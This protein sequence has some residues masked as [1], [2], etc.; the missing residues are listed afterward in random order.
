M[1]K[2]K[3]MP[4]PRDGEM[5]E[6]FMD[7]CMSDPMMRDEM[8]DRDQRQEACEMRW[9]D[10]K[11]SGAR[12]KERIEGRKAYSVLNVKKITERHDVHVLNGV[13][14][15]PRVDRVKD[16]VDPMGARFSLPM[17]LLMQHNSDSPIGQVIFAE[18]N[19]K[20]IPFEAVIPKITEP[21][22]VKDRIDEAVHSLKYD[23]I[24]A[25]SIGF[26]AEKDNVEFMDDGGIRFKEW[27]WLELSLVTIPANP[28]ARITSVKAFDEELRAALGEK[29]KSQKSGDT[30]VP[31]ASGRIVKNKKEHEVKTIKEKIAAFEARR[32]ANVA[33]LDQIMQQSEGE[34]LPEDK[35]QEFDSLQMEVE[36]IDG[37]LKRLHVADRLNAEKA[38]PISPSAGV[39]PDEASKARVP[40]MSGVRVT[41]NLE[42]GVRFARKAMALARA[43][44]VGWG[45]TPE[46]VYRAD[47]R[48]M[49]TAPEVALALKT[50]VN[51]ADST[52]ATWASELAYAQN[53]DSEFVEFMRPMT[54][55]GR[56]QGWRNVPFNIRVASQTS[57]TTGYWVGQG[58]GIKPSAAATSSISLGITKVAGLTAITKELAML[59]SPNAELMVR[60]DLAREVQEQLDDALIDPDNGGE[61]NV[62]PA[63]LTYG[64]TPRAA[65]G[66]DYAAFKA[67]WKE[68]S[69]AMITAE[70]GLD[71]TVVLMS[72]TMAQA[73]SLMVTSLG[74][75]QFPGLNA[76][77]GTLLGHP[78]FTSSLLYHSTGSP[79]WGETIV[80]LKPGEVFL[81]DDGVANVEASDQVSIHMDDA[82]TQSS[83][84]TSTNT[85]VVSMFQ[86]DSIAVKA[87]RHINWTKARTAACAFI[88]GAAYV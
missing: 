1:S 21:G 74:N 35:Q 16:I 73:L 5:Q 69:A 84:A 56:I 78:V 3:E 72:S 88:R 58:K 83:S 7:R 40:A 29:R 22:V 61:T 62:K 18:P 26:S 76:T 85:S 53:I 13:A 51:A 79:N 86:T 10:S 70:L 67:D 54:L 34:T 81:A 38:A 17:P 60:N 64:V 65:S 50:A 8:P 63:S 4:M 12:R 20:G 48:W 14:S 11:S 30:N 42:P 49:D 32:A 82:T 31:G 6:D 2:E 15:T 36:Q 52:T 23:L 24:G 28:D 19:K 39:N 33:A 41:S 9:S 87:V 27:E 77:G 25:V 80:L 44:S 55:V 57:G 68:L 75:P 59:S 43:K 45:Q 46:M 37:H 71:G 66:T 47:R